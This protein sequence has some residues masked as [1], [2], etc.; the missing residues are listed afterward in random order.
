M[1]PVKTPDDY[2][3]ALTVIYYFAGAAVCL[4]SLF[5]I[6]GSYHADFVYYLVCSA[7]AALGLRSTNRN[8]IPV[9]FLVMLLAIEDLSLPELIFIASVISKNRCPPISTGGPSRSCCEFS[10]TADGLSARYGSC[11]LAARTL[12]ARSV[13][14]NSAPDKPW[15]WRRTQSFKGKLEVESASVA[16]IPCSCSSICRCARLAARTALQALTAAI[17]PNS[18]SVKG[19]RI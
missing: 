13:N 7:I 12:P 1:S 18:T 3:S 5:Q 4:V 17:V 8:A 2:R 11:E 19:I 16:A 6:P 9:S 15:T 10:T 14:T